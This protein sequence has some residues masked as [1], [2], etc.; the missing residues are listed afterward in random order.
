MLD[1]KIMLETIRYRCRRKFLLL[2]VCTLSAILFCSFRYLFLLF[3]FLLLF[4][5]LLF[6]LLWT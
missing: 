4:L 6:F 2:F 1:T 3:C 5:F